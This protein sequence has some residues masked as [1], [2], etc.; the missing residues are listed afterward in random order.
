[1]D[2]QS[3][4]YRAAL[5]MH[6]HRRPAMP[7]GLRAGLA[8]LEAL[9]VDRSRNGELRALVEIDRSHCG[10]CFADGIQMSTG[11][12]FGKGNIDRL[13]Y[14]KFAVTVID[15]RGARSVR[16]VA[17][18]EVIQRSQ[19][20]E[21]IAERRKWVPACQIDPRL[22]EDL[23]QRT[24][25]DPHWV[26]LQRRAC[27]PG[28]AAPAPAARLRYLHLRC[29]R[30]DGSG[31][32]CARVGGPDRLHPLRRSRGA[33]QACAPA[34]GAGAIPMSLRSEARP[35]ARQAEW[36]CLA[37]VRAGRMACRDDGRNHAG[38]GNP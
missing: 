16:V 10:T 3:E 9:G 34:G 37:P 26:P 38:R 1:M 22:S 31:A 32:L 29:V 28:R 2:P 17:R 15:N 30:R 19:E 6:G 36:G 24:L 8:A 5:L 25:T 4:L 33:G 23:I 20:S 12:T 13:G 18:P 27:P 14:G 11:C 7:L 21:F 35:P